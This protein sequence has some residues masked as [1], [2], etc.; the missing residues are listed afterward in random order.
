MP[1]GTAKSVFTEIAD[2][3]VYSPDMSPNYRF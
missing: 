3:Q 2:F 1:T